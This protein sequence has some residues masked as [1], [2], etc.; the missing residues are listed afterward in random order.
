MILGVLDK[1]HIKDAMRYFAVDYSAGEMRILAQNFGG[2]APSMMMNSGQA[3]AFKRE[4][5][6]WSKIKEKSLSQDLTEQINRLEEALVEMKK[7]REL[8]SE[9]ENTYKRGDVVFHKNIGPGLLKRFV[10]FNDHSMGMP[11]MLVL[12]S[13]EPLKGGEVLATINTVDGE[14]WA[15][16]KDI[17]PYT[18]NVKLLYEAERSGTNE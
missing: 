10:I 5:E 11:E 16:A 3:K 2:K 12:E 14:V 17:V 15:L 18:E 7:S 1:S 4:F 13:N 9:L 8:I 6:S